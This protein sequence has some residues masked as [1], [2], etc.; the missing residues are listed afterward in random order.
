MK[1]PG[2]PISPPPAATDERGYLRWNRVYLAVLI[3]TAVLIVALWL[4][5]ITFSS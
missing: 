2:T 1:E 3:Y 4:F 5:S